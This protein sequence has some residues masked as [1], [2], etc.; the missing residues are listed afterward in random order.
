MSFF[1]GKTLRENALLYDR[2]YNKN[3]YTSPINIKLDKKK[4][5]IPFISS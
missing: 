5:Y 4:K 3:I 2:I 1:T